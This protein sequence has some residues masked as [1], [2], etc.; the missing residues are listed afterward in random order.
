[1]LDYYDED[2]KE[3]YNVALFEGSY[4]CLP[5]NLPIFTYNEQEKQIQKETKRHYHY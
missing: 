1:M 2:V 4:L 5:F 3:C